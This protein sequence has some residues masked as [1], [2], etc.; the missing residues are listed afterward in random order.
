M[1]WCS[2]RA[3]SRASSTVRVTIVSCSNAILS[4]S[5][6]HRIFPCSMSTSDHRS[7]RTDP[8]RCPVSWAT[9]SA[10]SNNGLKAKPPLERVSLQ[11]VGSRVVTRHDGPIEHRVEKLQVL[12]NH[13]IP[14]RL[15][16]H[17]SDSA[18]TA[19]PPPPKKCVPIS[20]I[21]R[22]AL[23]ATS[24]AFAFAPSRSRCPRAIE[25]ERRWDELFQR[26]PDHPR[27]ARPR[28]PR[29]GSCGPHEAAGRSALISRTTE[30]FR[31]TLY[32]PA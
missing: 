30:R 21:E 26:S 15:A 1:A 16:S 5:A 24:S 11:Q 32:S 8:I 10:S 17:A 19:H 20:A 2:W 23:I 7:S 18:I 4:F 13:A 29:R 14:D 25:S 31:K 9:T 6:R 22:L 3:R 28:G 12:G 27:Q